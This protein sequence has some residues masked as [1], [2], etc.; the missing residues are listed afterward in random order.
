MIPDTI[1]DFSRQ[2]IIGMMEGRRRAMEEYLRWNRSMVA[3]ENGE[4]VHISPDEI[5]EILA[6][7]PTNLNQ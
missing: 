7:Y 2:V 4:I 5:R 6:T 3:G 1:S